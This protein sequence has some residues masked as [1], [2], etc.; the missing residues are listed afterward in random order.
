MVAA[1]GAAESDADRPGPA[2]RCF[3]TIRP[4]ECKKCSTGR[5]ARAVVFLA[6]RLRESHRES[7]IRMRYSTGLGTKGSRT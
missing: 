3:W 2:T 1:A 7:P 5:Y 4:V 6:C